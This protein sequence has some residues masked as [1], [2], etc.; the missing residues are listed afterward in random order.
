MKY[1]VRINY[2]GAV[3][4]TVEADCVEEAEE[5]AREWWDDLDNETIV[6]NLYPDEIDVKDD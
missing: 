1:I 6:Q 5:L 4:K 3:E 2:S